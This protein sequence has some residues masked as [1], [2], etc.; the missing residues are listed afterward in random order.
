DKT[1][2]YYAIRMCKWLE[3]TGF[4]SR[5]IETY[6]WFYKDIGSVKTS[7]SNVRRQQSSFFIPRNS[8]QLTINIYNELKG[9][10][11]SE[12]KNGSSNAKAVE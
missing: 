5:S 6:T 1:W 8:P 2:R 3:I 9:K 7:V 11:I 12:Y 10:K 4:L